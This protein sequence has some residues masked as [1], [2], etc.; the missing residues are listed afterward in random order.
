[1]TDSIEEA[2]IIGFAVGRA[3]VDEDSHQAAMVEMEHFLLDHYEMTT[4]ERAAAQGDQDER[5][6]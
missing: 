4:F 1:M 3:K 5:E 2:L 6:G